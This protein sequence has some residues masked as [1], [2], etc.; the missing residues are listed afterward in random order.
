MIVMGF[1]IPRGTLRGIEEGTFYISYASMG[2]AGINHVLQPMVCWQVTAML[3]DA[4]YEAMRI[5]TTT[6]GRLRER[7]AASGPAWSISRSRGSWTTPSIRP[8][9]GA[10]P[11]G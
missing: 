8:S 10:S 2:Y 1:R 9:G 3:E 7:A 4:G 6:A 11:G 5:P